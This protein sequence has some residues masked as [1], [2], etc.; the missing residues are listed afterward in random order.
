VRTNVQPA[1]AGDYSVVVTNAGGLAA[2][3]PATLT[4]NVP[5]VIS[6]QPQSQT[7]SVGSNVLFSVTATGTEPLGYQWRFNTADIAGATGS[8]YTL[9]N[10]Q[11]TNAGTTRW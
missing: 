10:A 1:D 2:S 9:N 11:T 8:T 6:A 7:V 5:P 3:D 4:V